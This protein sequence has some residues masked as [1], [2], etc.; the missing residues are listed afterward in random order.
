MPSPP[1]LQVFNA[2]S[3]SPV[4]VFMIDGREGVTPLDRHFARWA[5]RVPGDRMWLVLVNKAE[6][7]MAADDD[8]SMHALH[9]DTMELGLNADETVLVS[10]QNG[11]GLSQLTTSVIPFIDSH[12]EE[13]ERARIAIEGFGGGGGAEGGVNYSESSDE[14][15]MTLEEA[16]RLGEAEAAAAVAEA[17]QAYIDGGAD[18]QLAGGGGGQPDQ[19]ASEVVEMAI[20]GRPNVGKSSLL[21]ALVSEDRVV[22]GPTA[23]LTRDAV[24]SEWI[25]NERTLRLV[26][27]AGIRKYGSR[28]RSNELE[29]AAVDASMVALKKAMVAVLVVDAEEGQLRQLEL[30]LANAAL[31]EGRGLV[32]VANKSDLLEGSRNSY[33]NGVV[34]QVR[35]A[36]PQHGELPV[37]ALSAL[38]KDGVN[39]VLPTVLDAHRRWSQRIGTGVLNRW[40]TAIER[41]HPPPAPQGRQTRLKYM[42]QL[43]GRPPTFLIWCNRPSAVPDSYLS[44]L[45][46]NLR[47]EFDFHGVPVRI[48]LKSTSRSLSDRLET[49]RA[50]DGTGI[51]SGVAKGGGSGAERGGARR[52]GGRRKGPGQKEGL[53]LGSKRWSGVH[54]RGAKKKGKKPDNG[55]QG[56]QGGQG[57][58]GAGPGGTGPFA[59]V[60]VK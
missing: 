11:D 38:T 25:Y 28:D 31:N 50:R 27:T 58:P 42:T 17:S 5:R 59:G 12:A 22:T 15:D 40:L 51:A 14:E 32:L 13:R 29:Q 56:R 48:K 8:E 23:G 9:A 26:D 46:N 35:Q 16:M 2:V 18:G 34:A 55:G 20:I 19:T 37:L 41:H 44:F 47:D 33:R 60:S 54:G 39:R 45:R 52:S 21:N 1:P 24:A 30:S 43:K 49:E 53:G 3:G 4:G 7:F 57:D 36:I 10:A 6:V